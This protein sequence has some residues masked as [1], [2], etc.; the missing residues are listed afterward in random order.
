[1]NSYGSR[2]TGPTGIMFSC[3]NRSINMFSTPFSWYA[4]P[5]V[6][7]CPSHHPRSHTEP[8][9]ELLFLIISFTF[10]CPAFVCE[11][12]SFS[13]LFLSPPNIS[14]PAPS[15]LLLFTFYFRAMILID[16]HP[17]ISS[18]AIVSTFSSICNFCGHRVTVKFI[19]LMFHC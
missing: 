7:F 2:K 15:L 4:I 19:D 18:H 11:F 3:P 6:F 17:L 9:S 1:M 14:L 8:S 12:S 13:C 16:A 10:P 5:L